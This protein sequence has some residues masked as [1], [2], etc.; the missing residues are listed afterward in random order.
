MGEETANSVYSGVSVTSVPY[1]SFERKSNFGGR[2]WAIIII[3]A[4]LLWI[5]SGSVVHGLNIILPV[6][7][8]AYGLDYTVLLGWATPASWASIL[9]GFLGAKVCERK[10]PKFLILISLSIGGL[11]FGLLGTWG[12][13]TG[14]VT[15][16]SIVCFFDS[17]FA[18]VGG[19]SLIANWFPRKKGLA[20]GWCTMGQTFSTA[21]Y[22]PFLAF[23]FATFGVQ[24]GMWGIPAV[25]LVMFLVVAFVAT[26]TPEQSGCTPDNVPMTALEIEEGRREQEAYVCPFTTRQL[27]G[28]KDVWFM[29]LSFGGI[30]IVIV[31]L[32]SQL[33]P[34]LMAIGYDQGTAIL[35]LSVAAIAGVPGA[36][37]WGWLSQKIGIKK[38]AIAYALWY[39]A[40][41]I[42]NIFEL[43]TVTLWISLLMIGEA[44]GGATNMSM[45]IVAEKFPRRA[46][47][48][49]WGIVNPI[50]SVVRCCAF[51]ILAFGLAN[52]GGYSGAYCLLAVVAIISVV[53][54]WKTDTTPIAQ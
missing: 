53:L 14:F 40:A 45:S 10:G 47:V 16:F 50:Q 38:C 4:A 52:L 25:M 34:R 20:L 24:K 39:T 1:K 44:L 18:Y 22:V 21:T 29:G 3:E 42:L 26:N 5:S 17:S 49:A 8:S 33:V 13:T 30:Y 11:C 43:N 35:Y 23:M 31:G 51:A 27:L 54:I 28:M 6:V 9:A 2:G 48:K 37:L 32:L 15:L 46:F 41:L 19:P 7:S 12:T 36:Y